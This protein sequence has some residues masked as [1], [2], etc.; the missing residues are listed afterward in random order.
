MI[1]IARLRHRHWHLANLPVKYLHFYRATIQGMLIFLIFFSRTCHSNSS[2][3]ICYVVIY[4]F[5]DSELPTT[6][7]SESVMPSAMPTTTVSPTHEHFP[8]LSPTQTL[9][10]SQSLHPTISN[11]PSGSPRPSSHPVVSSSAHTCISSSLFSFILGLSL[12][13]ILQME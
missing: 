5:V 3:L 2:L 9:S 10:P 12:M 4:I 8:S 13:F 7:P 6:V 11:E 1:T